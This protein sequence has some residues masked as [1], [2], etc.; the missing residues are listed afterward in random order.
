MKAKDWTLLALAAAEGKPLSPVQLQKSLFLL[1]QRFNEDLNEFYTFDAYDYGP[2]C[3]QIYQDGRELSDEGLAHIQ[4][5]R[6]KQYAATS[7]GLER[8]AKLRQDDSISEA[9]KYL[10]LAVDWTR[11]LSFQDLVR[12]IY[13]SFPEYRTNSVFKDPTPQRP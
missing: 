12:S 5:G 7:E 9:V 3:K 13:A 11:R 10:Q 6:W 1:G 2:F 8:A 4:I